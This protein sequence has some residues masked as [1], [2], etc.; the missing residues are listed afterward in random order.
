MNLFLVIN[1]I[2][3]GLGTPRKGLECIF[4]IISVKIYQITKTIENLIIFLFDCDLK[5]SLTVF[6]TPVR[7]HQP[8]NR[9]QNNF[10][11]DSDKYTKNL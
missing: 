3:C 6:V 5:G 4:I 1:K 9:R 8:L 7:T 10:I 11:D 2:R